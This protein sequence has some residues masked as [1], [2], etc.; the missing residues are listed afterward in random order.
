MNSKS[1]KLSL[2]ALP[3][4]LFLGGCSSEAPLSPSVNET[5]TTEATSAS[6]SLYNAGGSSAISAN[7]KACWG[8]ASRV[9]A[10]MGDMGEHASQEP[11]PRAGLRNLARELYDAGVIEDDSMQA[12]GQFVADALGLSIDACM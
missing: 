1:S 6:T 9:F 3:L 2:I 10:K 11:T 8:Q 4:V 12:L 5:P 7:G